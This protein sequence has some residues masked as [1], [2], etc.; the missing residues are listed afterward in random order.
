MENL[1][2]YYRQNNT[3]TITGLAKMAVSFS[4][5]SFLI[6]KRLVFRNNIWYEKLD[7]LNP[8]KLS[9]STSF[10]GRT[11]LWTEI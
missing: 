9:L 10:L 2:Q 5:D 11:F 6:N 3:A 4:A 1:K 8:K 7:N